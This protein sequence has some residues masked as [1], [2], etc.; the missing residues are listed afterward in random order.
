MYNW[1][2]IWP[3]LTRFDEIFDFRIQCIKFLCLLLSIWC[4]AP[5]GATLSASRYTKELNS[6]LIVHPNPEILV[7][8]TQ[9]DP[10]CNN[11]NE[12]NN[13]NNNDNKNNAATTKVIIM[14]VT[15]AKMMVVMLMPFCQLS[16]TFPSWMKGFGFALTNNSRN[17]QEM[18]FQIK[19]FWQTIYRNSI[20]AN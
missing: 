16:N 19:K 18:I 20:L 6:L 4:D 11:N 2:N 10:N 5:T 17:S 14:M 3:D 1:W 8:P 12:N 7:L 13:E 15:V 9:P